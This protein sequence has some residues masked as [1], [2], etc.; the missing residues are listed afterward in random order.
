[1]V[2]TSSSERGHGVFNLPGN[3]LLKSIVLA[4]HSCRPLGPLSPLLTLLLTAPS[5]AVRGRGGR[6]GLVRPSG[7]GGGG[8]RERQGLDRE[9][10]ALMRSLLRQEGSG[11]VKSLRSL[12]RRA[13]FAGG[14]PAARLGI[15]TGR[16]LI[17]VTLKHWRP[18]LPN[19]PGVTQS[20]KR[21]GAASD[22]QSVP[23]GRSVIQACCVQRPRS[24][25]EPVSC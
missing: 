18:R 10:Q 8:V 4:A 9:V 5:L 22:L 23:V 20:Q 19:A 14:C 21:P 2:A 11:L 13:E 12:V 17:P 1:M 3:E 25:R 15:E 24:L 6:E 7:L 16:P